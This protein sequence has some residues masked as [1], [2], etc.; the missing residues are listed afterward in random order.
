MPSLESLENPKSEVASEIYTAD[1]V[2]L[3]KYFRENRTPVEYEELSPNLVNALIATEDARF[4]EHS[5][6]DLTGLFRVAFKS[7]LMGQSS[8]GGGSTLSQQLAK[9]LFE[10]RSTSYEGSLAKSNKIF[11]LPGVFMIYEFK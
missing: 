11:R 1:G 5:G 9:N 7:V 6:I 10:T 8:S 2:L 3:G 4:E